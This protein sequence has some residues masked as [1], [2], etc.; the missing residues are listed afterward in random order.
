MSNLPT[1]RKTTFVVLGAKG[2]T[3]RQIVAQLLARPEED[4]RRVLA[5]VRNPDAVPEG[6]FP[7][8][9]PRLEIC[10]HEISLTGPGL[11]AAATD[12]ADDIHTV[13]YAAAGS[14]YELC[15]IVDRMGPGMVGTA[16][17][18]AG[19]TECRVVL[20]SSQLVDPV[21]RWS[22]VRG[23]LNTINT[24]F[25]HA[26]G[27]MDFKAQG[28]QMLRES[29]V[30]SWTILRP[31]RLTN[32]E[33]GSSGVISMGQTNASFGGG[34]SPLTRA[35]LAAVAVVT[36]FAPEARNTTVEIGTDAKTDMQPLDGRELFGSLRKDPV[37]T[38]RNS[39]YWSR[40][41]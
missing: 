15:K 32:G 20:V 7:S 26:E 33:A 34:G 28:E 24:G 40:L 10:K 27:M 4:V 22:L 5:C 36:A 23:I 8:G 1:P 12:S 30:A 17:A 31:G 19:M 3:G 2:A 39:E 18:N 41:Q 11:P 35:D 38:G 37:P 14:G 21:N 16:A 9:D 6:T 25:F 13:F 29:G